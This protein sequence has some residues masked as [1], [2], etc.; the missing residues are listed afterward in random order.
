MDVVKASRFR[1]PGWGA[2]FSGTFASLLLASMSCLAKKRSCRAS[3]CHVAAV[4]YRFCC[5][6]GVSSVRCRSLRAMTPQA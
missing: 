6:Q 5:R 1:R 3:R 2:S 4:E